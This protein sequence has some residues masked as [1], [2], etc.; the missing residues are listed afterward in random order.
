M[1]HGNSS[2]FLDIVMFHEAVARD[3]PSIEKSKRKIPST[4]FHL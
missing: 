4:N 1:S 3:I 2:V